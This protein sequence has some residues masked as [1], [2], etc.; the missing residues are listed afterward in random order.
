[1]FK[2]VLH[3]RNLN[4]Q[5]TGKGIQAHYQSREMLFKLQ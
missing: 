4:G 3:K 2:W 1:M 5:Y